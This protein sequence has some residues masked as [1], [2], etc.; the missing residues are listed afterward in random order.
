MTI[1]EIL[2]GNDAEVSNR[3]KMD[4]GLDQ[5]TVVTNDIADNPSVR[6]EIKTLL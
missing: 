2:N 6:N 1:R 3:E 5:R 4:L